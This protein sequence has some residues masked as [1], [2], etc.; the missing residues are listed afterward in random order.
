MPCFD[1][2][3]GGN[4]ANGGNAPAT[5]RRDIG[6]AARAAPPDGRA[7]ETGQNGNLGVKGVG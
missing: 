3:L 6:V 1:H 4:L 5:L 7:G 2:T